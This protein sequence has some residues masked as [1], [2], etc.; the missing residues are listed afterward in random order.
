MYGDLMPLFPYAGGKRRSVKFI[1]KYLR[2]TNTYVEPFFGSGAVF[3]YMVNKALAKKFVI[4]D[5]SRN[6]IGVYKAIRADCASLCDELSDLCSTFNNLSAGKKEVMFF[7]IRDEVS[8]GYNAAKYMFILKTRFG[9]M[10]R[11]DAFGNTCDTSGHDR[12][13]NRIVACN[14]EQINWWHR[15]LQMAEICQCDFESMPA[16]HDDTIVFCDPPYHASKIAYGIEFSKNDQLRCLNWCARLADRPDVTVLLSN[17]D[18]NGVFSKRVGSNVLID[19]YEVT[20]SAGENVRN[21]ETIMVWNQ[22]PHLTK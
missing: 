1:S 13:S 16:I 15:A 5:I 9:A 22:K 11:V 2:R 17:R 7:K 6:V 18:T 10:H 14:N 3:C 12:L 8:E 20:Y 19:H 21:N 4:N